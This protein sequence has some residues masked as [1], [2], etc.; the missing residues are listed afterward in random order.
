MVESIVA[1]GEVVVD[2]IAMD[3]LEHVQQEDVDD[4]LWKN[5]HNCEHQVVDQVSLSDR[6]AL[7]YLRLVWKDDHI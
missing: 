6:I 3:N 1:I 2:L 4:H 7:R 5:D